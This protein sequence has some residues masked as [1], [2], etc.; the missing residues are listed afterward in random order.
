MKIKTLK[1]KDS[2]YE[3]AYKTML[4]SEL[5]KEKILNGI[6]GKYAVV[7][8]TIAFFFDPFSY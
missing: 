5:S 2:V 6:N 4:I 3:I 7:D 8:H 1:S